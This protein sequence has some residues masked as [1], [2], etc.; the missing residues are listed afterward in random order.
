M[1]E[2][3]VSQLAKFDQAFAASEELLVNLVASYVV[4]R[5]ED[6]ADNWPAAITVM[7]MVDSLYAHWDFDQVASALAAAAVLIASSMDE[8]DGPATPA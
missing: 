6:A 1:V 3:E 4:R 2:I 8:G 5:K 7:S